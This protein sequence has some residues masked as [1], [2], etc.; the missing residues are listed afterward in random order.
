MAHEDT[1]WSDANQAKGV[2]E[3]QAYKPAIRYCYATLTKTQ[4]VHCYQ[5]SSGD[6]WTQTSEWHW[7]YWA[8]L[9][10]VYPSDGVWT[11]GQKTLSN[12][13]NRSIGNGSIEGDI[14]A[15]EREKILTYGGGSDTTEVN[16][17]IPY[18][19]NNE[20]YYGFFPQ[21]YTM[22]ESECHAVSDYAYEGTQ[23]YS[24]LPLIVNNRGD[25]WSK[26]SQGKLTLPQIHAEVP[27]NTNTPMPTEWHLDESGKLTMPVLREVVNDLGAFNKCQRLKEVIIPESV[28]SIGKKSFRETSLKSVEIAS[29]CTY[30]ETSFPSDCRIYF[31]GGGTITIDSIADMESHQIGR[32]ITM[33]INEL[34]G[35]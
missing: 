20:N 8:V 16:V 19:V 23:T 15:P 33:T 9:D 7:S 28:N 35:N 26:N 27:P 12:T 21:E 5:A 3:W 17:G 32:L 31:Y 1:Y 29:D 10:W 18:A 2:T 4:V 11:N 25:L 14:S 6:Y 34:E 13:W 30:Y 22:T 24:W